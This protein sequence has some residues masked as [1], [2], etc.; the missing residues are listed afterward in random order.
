MANSIS[1]KVEGL[2]ELNRK[3][4]ALPDEIRK[5]PVLMRA[6]HDGA[7][8]IR[9]E[10]KRLAPVLQPDPRTGKLDERRIVGN[11]RAGIV[12]HT[13]KREPD[14]VLVRVRNRGYIFGEG[15]GA[16]SWRRGNPNYWWL[17]EFGTS[18][19]APRPFLR[20][21]FEGK[22]FAALNEI[23]RSLARGIDVVTRRLQLNFRRAA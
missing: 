6:L 22:K 1:V 7:R 13:D 17:L 20:P 16:Q 8:I 9:D 15:K 14:T 18:K 23:R 11:L 3:L 5:G 2:A 19:M 10:A 21:A 12:E 4:A